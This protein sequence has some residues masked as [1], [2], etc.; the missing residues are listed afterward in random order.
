MTQYLGLDVSLKETKL[1]C[2]MKRAIGFG[3]ADARLS[4]LRSLQQCG[5]MLPLRCNGL[6]LDDRPPGFRLRSRPKA[7]QWSVSMRVTPAL[8]RRLIDRCRAMRPVACSYLSARN[9]GG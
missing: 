9:K 1:T 3:V 7:Y 2:L 5:G 6:R 8:D 4:L